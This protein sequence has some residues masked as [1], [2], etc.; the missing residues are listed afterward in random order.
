M[1]SGI[2]VAVE[3]NTH[4]TGDAATASPPRNKMKN[5]DS[6]IALCSHKD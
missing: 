4:M 6:P 2:D 3:E 1:A 5:M